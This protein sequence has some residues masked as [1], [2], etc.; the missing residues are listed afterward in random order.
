MEIHTMKGLSADEEKTLYTRLGKLLV[1]GA[2][3]M[4]DSE[5]ESAG[6]SWFA[7]QRTTLQDLV[8]SNNTIRALREG[9]GMDLMVAIAAAI[10]SIYNVE[11]AFLLAALLVKTGVNTLC[12][13]FSAD[14]TSD[15]EPFPVFFQQHAAQGNEAA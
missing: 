5:Y 1:V 8:C 9:G 11:T 6:R 4:S 15:R 7:K 10:G 14:D 12:V 13:D 2:T 3:P